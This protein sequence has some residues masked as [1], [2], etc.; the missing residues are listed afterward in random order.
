MNF[1]REEIQA[2]GEMGLMGVFMPQEYG[3]AGLDA[4]SYAIAMEEISAGC[5]SCGVIMSVKILLYCDPILKFGVKAQ[6][7]KYL[8]PFASGKNLAVLL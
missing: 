7:D 5:A 6:W 3:G 8:T 1:P 4:M 2:I